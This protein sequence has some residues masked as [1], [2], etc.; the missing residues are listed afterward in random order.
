MA[1]Q[2]GGEMDDDE[3]PEA[4]RAEVEAAKREGANDE[5]AETEAVGLPEQEETRESRR[6]RRERERQEERAALNERTTNAERIAEEL[7]AGRLEDANR[8]ARL[9][10][11]IGQQGQQRQEAPAPKDWRDTYDKQMKKANDALAAGNMAE[12]Q[13]RSARAFEARAEASVMEKV[14]GLVP[15]QQA[16]QPGPRP[17]WVTAVESQFPDVMMHG[18]GTNAVAAFLGLDPGQLGPEKL[19]RAFTR[20]RTELG[21]AKTPATP[22]P[23]RERQRQMLASGPT[24]GGAR[25]GSKAE[26]T[27]NG[28]PKNYKEIARAAGMK[29]EDYVKSFAKMN[30]GNVSRGE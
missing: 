18:N 27:V 23:E 14:R 20:A 9:E 8:L 28:V 6:Q 10:Q 15:Q 29:P 12:Y 4:V 19:Q 30:P 3:L 17:L 16:Q 24:N 25:G 13:E 22:S 1:K 7:R 21:L 5:P 2:Q 11:M 26:P